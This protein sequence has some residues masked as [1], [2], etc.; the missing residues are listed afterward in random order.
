VLAATVVVPSSSVGCGGVLAAAVVVPMS[1]LRLAPSE[2]AAAAVHW[3]RRW[4][5]CLWKCLRR[6]WRCPCC[7]AT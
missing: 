5:R 4:R 3:R 7:P 2:V 6:C 1:A